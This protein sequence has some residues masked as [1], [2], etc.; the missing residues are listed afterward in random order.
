M[1]IEDGTYS[2]IDIL[3]KVESTDMWDMIEVKG[4]TSVK[5][6]HIDDMAFQYRSFT[7]AGYNINKCLVMVIDNEYVRHGDIEPNK[8]FRLEDVTRVVLGKQAEIE[9]NLAGLSV[10][11]QSSEEPVVKIGAR[12]FKPFGCGY[13]RHCWKGIPGYSI[14]NVYTKDKAEEIVENIGS[15]E[16]A[17]LPSELKPKGV[18]ALDIQSYIDGEVHVDPENIRT[19]LNGLQYPLYYLDYETIGS[20]IP[21]FEGAR[22]FQAVPFQFSLHVQEAPEAKLKHFDFLHR[23]RSDPRPAFIKALIRLCGS[24]GSVVTYNQAFEQG[25]NNGLIAAF[26]EYTE[27]IQAINA[28]MVDLL[29]PFKKRWLYNPSQHGSASIKKVL[30]AFTDLSYEGMGIGNGMDASSQYANFMQN[31]L[32]DADCETLFHNLVEYCHLD[33]LAMKMLVDVLIEKAAT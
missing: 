3:R 16:V 8:L 13:M 7:G 9:R 30:P 14:Y 28:R 6:Y 11:M 31:G 5:D 4:S 24:T 33:T 29:V 15:Y 1:H 18:K 23:E 10:I 12:C 25:V 26:P 22:P 20:A 32:S 2:R 27:L 17:S 21:P 19:F